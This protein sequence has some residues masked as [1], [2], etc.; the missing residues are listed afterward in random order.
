MG[1]TVEF[2]DAVATVTLRWPEQ[3]NALGPDEAV[4]VTAALGA[5]VDG[6]ARAV[7]LT[8]EGAFCAGGNLRGMAAR[9]DM[10]AEDRRRLVYGAY[11]GL[12]R[13]LVHLP[14]PTLAAVDGPAVGMGLDLAL[15]C[16]SR[17]VGPTG[18]ARQGWAA[19]GAVPGTG[20][21]LLLRLRAPGSL[22]RILPG[23]PKLDAAAL[24]ALGLAEATGDRSAL[25]VAGERARQLAAIPA[26]TLAAYVELD[27]QHLRAAL[28]EH[29][30]QV[31]EVQV[32]MLADPAFRNR[33]QEAL[34]KP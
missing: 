7:I 11:Q 16:D 17:L 2:E 3:R 23:Q 29:L 14:V 12:M 32:R 30:E 6:G 24:S 22:W 19:I 34:R 5:A 27:R 13:A 15:A 31:L 9:A 10:P 21:L 8:G 26:H 18:W 20:G 33:A 1:V 28:A 4:Q 25:D